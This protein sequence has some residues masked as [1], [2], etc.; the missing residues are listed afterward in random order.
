SPL[1]APLGQGLVT[2]PQ[3]GLDPLLK[4]PGGLTR[5]A[6]AQVGLA[7]R[8]PNGCLEL[9]GPAVDWFMFKVFVEGSERCIVPTQLPK[10]AAEAEEHLRQQV[11]LTAVTG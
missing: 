2:L 7:N 5:I 10:G 11:I 4:G 1:A 6:E 8:L 3:G 9:V